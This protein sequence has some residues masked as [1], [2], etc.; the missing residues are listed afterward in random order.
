MV[1]HVEERLEGFDKI[2]Q[3]RGR[4]L[5]DEEIA[6]PRM[7]ERTLQLGY[8]RALLAADPQLADVRNNPRL[9]GLFLARQTLAHLAP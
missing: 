1:G 6:L 5:L 8:S 3:R 7:V 9:S 2:G 4:G